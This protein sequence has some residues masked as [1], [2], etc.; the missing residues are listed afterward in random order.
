MVAVIQLAIA[1][2]S[3]IGGLLFDTSGYHGTF[4]ASAFVLLIATFLT[5]LPARTPTPRTARAT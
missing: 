1:L 3:S 5:F 2:G 4:V